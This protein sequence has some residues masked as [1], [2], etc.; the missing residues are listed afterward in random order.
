MF[1]YS[2]GSTTMLS[3]GVHSGKIIKA[4][5]WNNPNGPEVLFVDIQMKDG[6]IFSTKLSHLLDLD[7]L[8]RATGKVGG[9]PELDEKMLPNLE[10]TFKTQNKVSPKDGN[11]YCNIQWIKADSLA[12][13]PNATAEDMA[14][15]NP[16]AE[17][18][19]KKA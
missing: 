5:V 7:D 13:N 8:A 4:N 10:V 14:A 17:E 11:E 16:F 12:A 3:D 6:V 15:M 1:A 19:K 2:R 18:D 9:T